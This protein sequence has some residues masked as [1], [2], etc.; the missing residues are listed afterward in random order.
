MVEVV[1]AFLDAEGLGALGPISYRARYRY[2][3]TGPVI[4]SIQL[5]AAIAESTVFRNSKLAV[6]ITPD[7]QIESTVGGC[8]DGLPVLVAEPIDAHNSFARS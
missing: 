5:P 3:D 6:S 8:V 4:C 2:A 7:G 1:E